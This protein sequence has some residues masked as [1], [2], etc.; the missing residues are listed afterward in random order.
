MILRR[1]H[2]IKTLFILCMISCNRK[3]ELQ[4]SAATPIPVAIG[5][6]DFQANLEVGKNGE[7]FIFKVKLKQIGSRARFLHVEDPMEYGNAVLMT[8][9]RG[10]QIKSFSSMTYSLGSFSGFVMNPVSEYNY[11]FDFRSIEDGV[12]FSKE[13]DQTLFVHV[14]NP[15]IWV[16]FNLRVADYSSKRCDIIQIDSNSVEIEFPFNPRVFVAPREESSSNLERLQLP[17][18]F[19]PP[20]RK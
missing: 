4:G 3:E 16:R 14:K 18:L 15:K 12:L 17:D 7:N 13:R 19:P 8:E 10:N 9:F 20:N 6:E 2:V 1:S 11:N 5:K